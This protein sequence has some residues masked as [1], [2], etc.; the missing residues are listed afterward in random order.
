M[1]FDPVVRNG[2]REWD[3]LKEGVDCTGRGAARSGVENIGEDMPNHV[4]L[5]SKKTNDYT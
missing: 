5:T 1:M 4:R 3:N 2:P